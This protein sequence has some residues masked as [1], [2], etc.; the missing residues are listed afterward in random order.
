M[1]FNTDKDN[2]IYARVSGAPGVEPSSAP[3]PEPEPELTSEL[4][5]VQNAEPAPV[6]RS[7]RVRRPVVGFDL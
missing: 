7:Q 6:R 3:E 4:T 2:L 5:H 1:H